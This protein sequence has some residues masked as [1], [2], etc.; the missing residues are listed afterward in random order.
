[1]KPP[2][3]LLTLLSLTESCAVP[4][5]DRVGYNSRM[6]NVLHLS[7]SSLVAESQ[8]NCLA[9]HSANKEKSNATNSYFFGNI[10]GVISSRR[11]YER[12]NVLG[13]YQYTLNAE[14]R[15]SYQSDKTE[16]EVEAFQA[17]ECRL[18]DEKDEHLHGEIIDAIRDQ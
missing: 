13:R 6:S 5:I 12:A 1:M 4:S 10:P 7:C 16:E 15:K 3:I 17:L 9:L 14:I 2:S 11:G 18:D 8:T